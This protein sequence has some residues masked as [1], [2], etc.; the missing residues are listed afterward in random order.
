MALNPLIALQSKPLDVGQTFNTLLTNIG[1][2]DAIRQNRE[3]APIRNQILD[4]QAQQGGQNLQ[5]SQQKAFQER[6]T[7]RLSSVARFAQ[8]ILPALNRDDPQEALQMALQ[9]KA[10]LDQE[11]QNNPG[12]QL[13]TTEVDQVIGLLQSGR[14][15]D[16]LTAN[17]LAEQAVQI[18]TRA[19]LLD[20]VVG[21]SA[22]QR[23]FENFVRIAEDP[24]SSQL[25]RDSANRALGNK[26]RV[27]GA[28]AK[29]TDVGGV[30]HV[31]DPVKQ[32]LVPAFVDNKRVTSETVSSSLADIKG[33][34][35]E[36]KLPSDLEKQTQ[37]Q[38][39][40]R[41]SE[42]TKS[43]KARASSVNK[44][45]RFLKAFNQGAESGA[46]RAGLSFLPGVFTEQ[47][48]F[49]ERF[50]AFSE[51][52]A[53]EQLKASG[54]TRPTDADVEGMKRSMF[55][56]GRDEESN[57]KLLQEFID[58]QGNL[59][60]ELDE[61]REAKGLGL[62]KTFTGKTESLPNGISESDIET[63]MELRNMTREQVITKLRG[64]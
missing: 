41:I 24:E 20:K 10:R 27:V 44:A 7:N 12:I 15:E 3:Q 53:R 58:D 18:G 48:E 22:K 45:K 33:A 64:R 57:K 37:K 26:A 19:G 4:L 62:L 2:L 36:A 51:V 31:F 59:D 23:E 25:Q 5:Q 30:P 21:K 28:A 16:Q 35:E 43:E 1:N 56:V 63:T 11:I 39:M 34:E 13:D 29:T 38:N 61:L 54:E 40:Q 17:R 14:P 47:A 49:D 32:T 6:Q 55:G 50:N 52:A 9:H 60:I 42:L 8:Q 46:T